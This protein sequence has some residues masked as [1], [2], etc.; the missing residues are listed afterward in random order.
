VAD[1]PLRIAEGENGRWPDPPEGYRGAVEWTPLA[2]PA[3]DLPELAAVA[4]WPVE[5]RSAWA[6]RALQIRQVRECTLEEAELEAAR[7]LVAEQTA[8]Q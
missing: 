4:T 6:A 3:H 1:R 8:A 7:E 5:R 2:R